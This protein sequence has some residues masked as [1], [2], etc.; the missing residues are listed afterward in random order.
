MAYEVLSAFLLSLLF[1]SNAFFAAVDLPVQQIS[2]SHCL[3]EENEKT[4]GVRK[5]HDPVRYLQD[6][7]E[8][9]KKLQEEGKINKEEA[10]EKI[11]KTEEKIK[12]IEE[13]R[14]LP[15]EKKK[16]KLIEDFKTYIDGMV[17]KE[18]ISR[19]KADKLLKEYEEKVKQWDGNGKPPCFK[20]NHKCPAGG[21]DDFR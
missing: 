21:K 14:K 7:K 4:S 15:P 18:I 6:K 8:K 10:D 12:E 9:I 5:D 13:F 17:E 1:S 20:K 16:K 2:G 19:E 3:K 11:K